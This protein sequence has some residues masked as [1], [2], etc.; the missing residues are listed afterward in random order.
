MFIGYASQTY[1]PLRYWIREKSTFYCTFRTTR[2]EC[3]PMISWRWFCTELW[4]STLRRSHMLRRNMS[5]S[6]SLFAWR[7]IRQ[8]RLKRH[9][10]ATYRLVSKEL[11]GPMLQ[12][13]EIWSCLLLY[14]FTSLPVLPT[15]FSILNTFM[16]T[17]YMYISLLCFLEYHLSGNAFNNFIK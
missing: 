17:I 7:I 10:P 15:N 9:D 3:N 8:W 14:K 16:Y 11:H 5:P 13:A 2:P 6:Y 4:P 12:K 1:W